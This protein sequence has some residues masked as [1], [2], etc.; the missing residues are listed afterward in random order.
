MVNMHFY[1]KLNT[2]TILLKNILQTKCLDFGQEFVKNCL[3]N[4]YFNMTH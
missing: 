2:L 1:T 4:K 3:P